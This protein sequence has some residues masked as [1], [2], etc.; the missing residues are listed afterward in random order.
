MKPQCIDQECDHALP[1]P[2]SNWWVRNKG[3]MLMISRFKLKE[4]GGGGGGNLLQCHFIHHKSHVRSPKTEPK[5]LWWE[6]SIQPPD[7]WYNVAKITVNHRWNLMNVNGYN[8]LK[9]T[10]CTI[11]YLHNKVGMLINDWIN[12]LCSSIKRDK[13]N[14][15]HKMSHLYK[16]WKI[17]CYYYNLYL[18]KYC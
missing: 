4:H 6:V 18:K 10:I 8:K 1:G 7:I 3:G 9:N 5:A 11:M 16:K 14:I 15:Y 13:Y 2:G 17:Q 12:V